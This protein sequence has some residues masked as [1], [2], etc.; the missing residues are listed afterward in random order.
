VLNGFIERAFRQDRQKKLAILFA[1]QKIKKR[2]RASPKR[3]M[4]G[5]VALTTLPQKLRQLG[6]QIS[7]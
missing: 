6:E 1:A 2:S 7:P 4:R 5:C 3:E